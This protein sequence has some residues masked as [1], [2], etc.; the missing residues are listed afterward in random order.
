[1][2]INEDVI[3]FMTIRVDSLDAEPS[4][5]MRSKNARDEKNKRDNF[6]EEH[7]SDHQ[8]TPPAVSSGGRSNALP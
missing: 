8:R 5:M 6:K 7:Y 1:M 4:V 2:R 3:R